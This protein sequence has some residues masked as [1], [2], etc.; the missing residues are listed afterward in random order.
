MDYQIYKKVKHCYWDPNKHTVSMH[1]DDGKR[2]CKNH[3]IVRHKDIEFSKAWNPLQ[4]SVLTDVTTRC[5]CLL[6]PLL[7]KTDPEETIDSI[8]NDLLTNFPFIF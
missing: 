1:F 5:I 2:K 4:P 6:F 7:L 8:L 3:Q